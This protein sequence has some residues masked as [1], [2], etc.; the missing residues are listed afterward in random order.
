MQLKEKADISMYVDLLSHLDESAKKALI[1]HLSSTKLDK[2]KRK[3]KSFEQLF[4]AWKS[5]ETAEEI[6]SSIRKARVTKR[7]IESF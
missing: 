1:A 4:G 7:K 3:S 6:I 2:K 5:S